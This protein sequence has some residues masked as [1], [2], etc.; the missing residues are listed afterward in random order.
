[1]E[2]RLRIVLKMIFL[3]IGH[4]Y[5][6]W[7]LNISILWTFIVSSIGTFIISFVA[8]VIRLPNFIKNWYY[9]SMAYFGIFIELIISSFI[10]HVLQIT[11]VVSKDNK[12]KWILILATVLFAYGYINAHMIYVNTVD[13]KIKKLKSST[14]IAHLTDLHIGCAYGKQF[15][16]KICK[17]LA[18][19][20]PD[21]VVI[22]GDLY[23][24]SIEYDYTAI[25]P[26]DRLSFPVYLIL[27]N[28]DLLHIQEILKV[29]KKSKMILMN[30]EVHVRG[31]LKLIGLQFRNKCPNLTTT[32]KEL[33]VLPD[34]T[35]I[36]LYHSPAYTADDLAEVG[37]SLHLAGH[38]HGGQL[39]PIHIIQ[40]LKYK[41]LSGLHHSKKKDAWVYVS[42]G[43]GTTGSP[44]R[45][46]TKS[47]IDVIRLHGN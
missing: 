41:Y 2:R 14:C 44:L 21:F 36:L 26:F 43:L 13:I 28:H 47:A 15:V 12:G 16:E 24:G 30:D 23:D 17:K 40:A 9:I 8:F 3:F 39:F 18:E 32:L 31:E 7:N 20:K 10:F 25:E 34:T 46:G 27:G 35:N 38:T 33:Q 22:T 19:I 1:M 42:E 5:I 4:L 6:C 37:I 45:I 11:R 29:M